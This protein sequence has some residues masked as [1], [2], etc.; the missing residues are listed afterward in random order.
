MFGVLIK[1]V[2]KVV[3]I[4]HLTEFT[5][6]NK[7]IS[8]Q[9]QEGGVDWST[10]LSLNLCVQVHFLNLVVVPSCGWTQGNSQF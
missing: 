2:R 9:K 3:S 7:S 8:Y 1:L 5:T 10:G 6:G 4:T